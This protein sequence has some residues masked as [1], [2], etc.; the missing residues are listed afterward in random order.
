MSYTSDQNKEVCT[1]P[2]IPEI[3]SIRVG[4]EGQEDEIITKGGLIQ[5]DDLWTTEALTDRVKSCIIQVK[6]QKSQSPGSSLQFP[7][8]RKYL[9]YA[10]DLIETWTKIEQANQSHTFVFH[11]SDLLTGDSRIV[12]ELIDLNNTTPTTIAYILQS[13]RMAFCFGWRQLVLPKR[14]RRNPSAD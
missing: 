11:L 9:N 13:S 14:C 5:V 3:G 10:V 6:E 4:S 12:A 8:D 7:Y 1:L 2:L